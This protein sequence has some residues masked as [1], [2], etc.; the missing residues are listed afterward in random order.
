[1]KSGILGSYYHFART[2][3]SCNGNYKL[4]Y[5]AK[6]DMSAIDSFL[7]VVNIVKNQ[8]HEY[9]SSVKGIHV[10]KLLASIK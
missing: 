3:D 6:R 8:T 9:Y 7:E 4:T 1:M 10:T 5:G 2:Q